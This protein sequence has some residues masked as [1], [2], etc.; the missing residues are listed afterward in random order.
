LAAGG[1]PVARTPLR[2]RSAHLKELEQLFVQFV[3]IAKELCLVKL[4]TVPVDGTK[5]KANASRRKAKYYGRIL[6][7]ET[8]L[9]R[10]E[11]FVALC[12]LFSSCVRRRR[13]W[14][15]A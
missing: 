9:N 6:K 11:Q 3:Q 10:M 7:T 1:L 12:D 15:A 13:N 14:F 8:P 2:F 5:I 4:G